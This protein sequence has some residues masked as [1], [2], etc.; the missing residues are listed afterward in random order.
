MCTYNQVHITQMAQANS[1]SLC[2][3]ELHQDVNCGDLKKYKE[4]PEELIPTDELTQPFKGQ[5]PLILAQPLLQMVCTIP[6]L[7]PTYAG[8]FNSSVLRV[9]IWLLLFR[10]KIII[11]DTKIELPYN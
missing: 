8:Y 3:S 6:P 2:N 5:E 9:L 11:Q 1:F 4:K 7:V 10:S